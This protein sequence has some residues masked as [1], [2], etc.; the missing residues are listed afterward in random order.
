M[1]L[2]FWGTTHLHTNAHIR[3]LDRAGA[4]SEEFIIAQT[5]LEVF[6]LPPVTGTPGPFPDDLPSHGRR[7]L[8]MV[9]ALS[10]IILRLF[11]QAKAFFQRPEIVDM[12]NLPSPAYK[13]PISA[14]LM[15]FLLGKTAC[16][17]AQ[18]ATFN[19]TGPTNITLNARAQH[20]S[21]MAGCPPALEKRPV[22]LGPRDHTTTDFRYTK[23]HYEQCIYIQYSS[24]TPTI[25]SAVSTPSPTSVPNTKETSQ[26]YQLAVTVG[27]TY[28]TKPII[29]Q[30]HTRG[31]EVSFS[32]KGSRAP[33][34]RIEPLRFRQ[35]H[36]YRAA[37][38]AVSRTWCR[39]ATYPTGSLPTP[40]NSY[41]RKGV[42]R[43][44]PRT[45]CM[46]NRP[47]QPYHCSDSI[48]RFSHIGDCWGRR[49][50]TQDSTGS[51]FP[52]GFGFDPEPPASRPFGNS[53]GCKSAHVGAALAPLPPRHLRVKI[54]GPL[55]A[56]GSEGSE[57]DSDNGATSTFKDA[58]NRTITRV[59]GSVMQTIRVS[60]PLRAFTPPAH[61]ENLLSEYEDFILVLRGM[62]ITYGACYGKWYQS[63]F[64][65][66]HSLAVNEQTGHSFSFEYLESLLN[67]MF[68]RFMAAARAPRIPVILPGGT[69][70]I[71][72][73]DLSPRRP[74][75]YGA[76]DS[77][78]TLS[79]PTAQFA[80]GANPTN[81]V[82]EQKLCF[83]SFLRAYKL[84]LR[85][86]NAPP[87]DCLKT[88]TR[89]H[90]KAL[91]KGF[92]RAKVLE[93]A[94]ISKLV[95]E[96]NRAGLITAINADPK[97]K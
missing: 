23:Q 39:F 24:P 6:T 59:K 51:L 50:G 46:A 20:N 47:P 77:H 76:T 13:R 18:I 30:A 38:V 73:F 28:V 5:F 40:P 85:T 10:H 79:H 57:G 56:P 62:A 25:G 12:G 35:R 41:N 97:L 16:P 14:T 27:P 89:L 7:S 80:R 74:T 96:E 15:H 8:Y 11:S 55:S 65:S 4:T 52:V 31:S 75:P 43:T 33:T 49:F 68:Y 1:C 61:L 44:L 3:H 22:R 71:T 36:N 84:N 42:G 60:E 26:P 29:P 9:P 72:P 95:T 32:V 83:M 78:P 67:D 58:A 93:I 91:P 63:A 17:P 2:T 45:T 82:G 69:V 34:S 37:G 48:G 64:Q 53:D 54:Q 87:K 92:S 66:M 94:R 88:C 90:H 81:V 86:T 70:V 21:G 19:N